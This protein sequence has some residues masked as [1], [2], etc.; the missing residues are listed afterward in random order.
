MAVDVQA[1]E[2][3]G[4]DRDLSAV[5]L[6]KVEGVAVFSASGRSRRSRRRLP[7]ILFSWRVATE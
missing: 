3:R 2:H 5:A 1:A 4:S 6:A 7:R